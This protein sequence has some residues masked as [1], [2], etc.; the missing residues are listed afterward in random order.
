MI[1]AR[2]ST[3]TSTTVAARRLAATWAALDCVGGWAGDLTE[4]LM[5]LGRMTAEIDALPAIGEEHVS[6]GG[7]RGAEGRKT[8]TATTLYDADGRVVGAGEHVW[9]AVDPGAFALT[10]PG[11]RF[12]TVGRPAGCWE[13]WAHG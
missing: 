4:R 9:I 3:R 12:S 6:S 10:R 1:A 13:A 8:F 11:Q 2:T 5:V 7:A